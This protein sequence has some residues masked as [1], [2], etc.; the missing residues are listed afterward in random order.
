M[1][2]DF[3]THQGTVLLY[4]TREDVWRKHAGPIAETV[5]NLA[6]QISQFEPVILGVLPEA[7]ESLLHQQCGQAR[8]EPMFYNDI[9]VRDSGAVS[10]GDHF[11]KMGFNAWGGDEGLYGDWSLDQTVPEQ[12]SKL[13]DLPLVESLLTAEG[14]NLVCDGQGTLVSIKS[15]FCN[16]NRNPQFDVNEI[17]SLLKKDLQLEQIVW[18]EDGLAYD[19]TGG[20]IDN[21]CAF[22]DE[23]TIL[24][25]W[26]DDPQNPQY[27]IVR[28]AYSVL[29]NAHN[30]AGVP[31]DIV[32]IPLP[33]CFQRTEDDCDG[34]IFVEGSKKRLVGEII[35]PSYINF[36][37][38]NAGV[39]LPVFGD[40]ADETVR[41]LFEK[42]FPERKIICFPAREILLGGG[43]IHCIT[44]NY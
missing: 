39:I 35:Q 32:K 24:L 12:M 22:A 18:I 36:A 6:A 38:V 40:P 13:L 21:L 10:A 8:I 34:L 3:K 2:A 20:H 31:F 9:W 42:I 29:A 17:E 19:E 1:K 25:A 27:Q 41:A 14:G 43:G 4:P 11:V 5:M 30:A 44:K 23:K 28:N 26:T 7:E 15:S 37:F 16:P 33:N